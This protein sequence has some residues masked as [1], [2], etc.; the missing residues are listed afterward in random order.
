[1]KLNDATLLEETDDGI[2]YFSI[3]IRSRNYEISNNSDLKD[4]LKNMGR[5][6]TIIVENKQ[7]KRSGLTIE[8][9]DKLTFNYDKFNPTRAGRY[10][11]LPKYFND[12]HACINI[13]NDDDKCF[14]YSIQCGYYKVYEKPHPERVTSYK[15]IY[16]NLNWD[17]INFPV[18]NNGVKRLEKNNETLSINVYETFQNSI[19]LNRRTTKEYSDNITHINLL[20]VTDDDVSHYIFIKDYDRLV[21][22]QTNKYHGK[23]YHCFYCQHGFK[24]QEL[25]S[26]HMNRGCLT[27]TGSSVIMPKRDETIIHTPKFRDIRNPF[28]IYADFECITKPYDTCDYDPDRNKP[29]TMDYQLHKP[30]GFKYVIV[31]GF[32]NIFDK[33]IYRGFDC[34]EV[35]MSSLKE[36]ETNL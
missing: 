4:V 22:S 10:I 8:K 17:D 26:L 3:K 29:F 30:C 31:D 14:M 15:H 34:V 2:E 11:P 27:V 5:D 33:Q 28:V 25:C 35:L 9:I 20:R 6:I 18:D 7:L 36:A 1:M 24:S 21:S 13:Q 19:I 16:D 32:G 12:K 23:K